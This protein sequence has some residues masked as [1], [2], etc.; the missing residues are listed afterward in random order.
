LITH[1][2][3]NDQK[4]SRRQQA[5]DRKEIQMHKHTRIARSAHLKGKVTA[6]RRLTHL[7]Q[8]DQFE[9]I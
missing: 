3:R 1:N 5:Q 8:P 9:R 6:A 7:E 2:Q 4:W